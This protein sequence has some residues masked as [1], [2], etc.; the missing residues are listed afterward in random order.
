VAPPLHGIRVLDLTRLLPGAFAT[1][2]LAELGA[3]VV[4][5]EDP[6][7]GDP[8]RSLPPTID[9]RGIYD[10]LLNRGKH[11][12]ALDLR[13]PA[14]MPVLDRLIDS[15]DVVIESFRP[16]TA[17]AI[18]VTAEQTRARRPRLIH[19]AITGYGQHGPYAERPGHDLNYVAEAGLLH[20]DRPHAADLP[21]MFIADVGG[22][23]MSA[24]AAILAA[25]F[26][27]E[28]SGDGA[29]LDISMYDAAVYWMMLPAARELT[30]R[31]AEA[32]G[33]LP[34]SGDHA[35]YNIYE[36]RDGRRLALGALEPKFWRGFCDAINRPDLASRQH[37]DPADQARLIDDIRAVFRERTS[38][39]WIRHFAAHEVCLSPVNTAVDV[40]ADPHVAA[41]QLVVPAEAGVRA[42]R[43]P[44]SA[45]P[46]PLRPAPLLGADT[47]AILASLGPA[48][49]E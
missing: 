23:A 8:T 46:A 31:G 10:R 35:C 4:K 20:V 38:D 5:V 44:F 6:E 45:A 40:L 18:G 27:R 15:C 17:R 26:A 28:R 11:S 14:S 3:E 41:R 43:A 12:V 16:K 34:T 13:L 49:I 30:D 48:R 37:T 21:R 22:G 19:C 36:T 42:F 29:S 32:V 2:M 47:A 24:V 9:G 1:L 39:D 33:E 7:R 25:L